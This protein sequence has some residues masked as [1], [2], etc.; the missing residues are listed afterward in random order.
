MTGI[1]R[2]GLGKLHG[3]FPT[4]AMGVTDP[5]GRLAFRRV[6]LGGGSPMEERNKVKRLRI[7]PTLSVRPASSLIKLP[8]FWVVI[9]L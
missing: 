7:V 6:V 3:G 4:I 5:K 9:L 8:P 1:R 2:K